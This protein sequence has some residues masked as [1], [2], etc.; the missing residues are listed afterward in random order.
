[1]K[2]PELIVALDVD[3]AG[4]ALALADSLGPEVQ[5]VKV[6]KQLFTREG[7]AVVNSLRRE[8]GKKVFLDLKF[9]D[10]PNTVAGAVRAAAS[11]GVEMVNIHASGGCAMIAAAARAVEN[12][13]TILVAVTVLTSLDEEETRR[14][15]W[16]DKPAE[17]VLRLARLSA[18]AGAAGMVCSAWEI[19]RLR[20]HLGPDFILV[21]PG[22]RPA[23]AGN[24][25]QKRVM[26]PEKAVRAG[27]DYLVVG[28]PVT[29]ADEPAR[30][31][32]AIRESMNSER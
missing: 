31:A 24:Q 23:Q 16:R 32:A 6:G 25:D 28:R 3:T 21:V 7:P 5:W 22:I 2:Q 10:I 18:E 19:E 1:M 14:L 9:H 17:Q 26:T 29:G 4:E 12:T 11:M 8:C 13:S 30:A 20:Y 27:A 15:G